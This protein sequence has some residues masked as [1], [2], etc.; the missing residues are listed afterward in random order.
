MPE[1]DGGG[2][3][4]PRYDDLEGGKGGGECRRGSGDSPA[5]NAVPAP[6]ELDVFLS[7]VSREAR[8]GARPSNAASQV[9]RSGD[10]EHAVSSPSS[11]SDGATRRKLQASG[12][13]TMR[14]KSDRRAKLWHS[15]YW[16]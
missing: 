4:A 15:N 6:S 10:K 16:N 8:I 11:G 7:C 13:Q 2:C 1:A 14:H 3:G 5:M 9:R 12:I